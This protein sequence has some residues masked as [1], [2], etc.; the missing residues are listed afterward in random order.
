MI[1]GWGDLRFIWITYVDVMSSCPVA[2]VGYCTCPAPLIANAIKLGRRWFDYKKMCLFFGRCIE[3]GIIAWGLKLF[4]TSWHVRWTRRGL[5]G[6]FR[7]LC[8]FITAKDS[9][10]IH[11]VSDGYMARGYNFAMGDE[12]I[13]TLRLILLKRPSNMRIQYQHRPC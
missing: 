4:V 12:D 1:L 3:L 5:M 9:T 8:L 2:G 10:C 13:T 11:G 6:E 7:E